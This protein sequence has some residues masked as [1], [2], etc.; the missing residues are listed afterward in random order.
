[1][2]IKPTGSV[3]MVYIGFESQ[4]PSIVKDYVRLQNGE[5][6][7]EA[8]ASGSKLIKAVLNGYAD[9]VYNVSI[10]VYGNGGYTF[11]FINA[12]CTDSATAN[13]N[14]DSGVL[15]DNYSISVKR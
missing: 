7:V 10:Y 14:F 3:D 12:H 1:M 8:A 4:K 15:L 13:A 5:A 9:G 11:N 6:Y 2:Q